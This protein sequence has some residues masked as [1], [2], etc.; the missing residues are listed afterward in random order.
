MYIIIYKA[1]IY[2]YQAQNIRQYLAGT[3]FNK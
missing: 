1:I 2:V 3:F